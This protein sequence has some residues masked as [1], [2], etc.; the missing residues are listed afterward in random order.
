VHLALYFETAKK[1]KYFIDTDAGSILLSAILQC[2]IHAQKYHLPI[3]K[4]K[5]LVQTPKGGHVDRCF[6]PEENS[7]N[8]DVLCLW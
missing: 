5:H 1:K 6:I 7:L 4:K 2:N 3:P 8:S